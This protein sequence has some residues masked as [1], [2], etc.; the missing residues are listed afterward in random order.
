M[1]FCFNF[2]IN[3]ILGHLPLVWY[4]RARA[5][6]TFTQRKL[7]IWGKYSDSKPLSP[8]FSHTTQVERNWGRGGRGIRFQ[9]PCWADKDVSTLTV[10]SE[11]TDKWVAEAPGRERKEEREEI[12]GLRI[13]PVRL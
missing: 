10:S 3:L 4:D 6:T 12:A 8:H 7:E 1:R 13:N 9:G 5:A 2:F 11:G